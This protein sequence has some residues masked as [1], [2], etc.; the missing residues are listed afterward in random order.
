[1]TQ[2]KYDLSTSDRKPEGEGKMSRREVCVAQIL[3]VVMF[4]TGLIAGLLIGVYVYHSD[5]LQVV[6]KVKCS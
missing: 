6:C 4:A 3:A 1:M 5:D 2:G